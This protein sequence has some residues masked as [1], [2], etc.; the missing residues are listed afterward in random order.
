[1]E[2]WCV[3]FIMMIFLHAEEIFS[4][5]NCLNIEDICIF[6]LASF[7]HY[8]IKSGVVPG[9]FNIVVDM[10]VSTGKGTVSVH[11]PSGRFKIRLTGFI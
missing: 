7:M 11:T 9:F 1:M 6:S 3:F 10:S 8:K 4:I 5:A 2:C